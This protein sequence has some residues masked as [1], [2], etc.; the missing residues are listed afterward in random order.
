MP[1]EP[2]SDPATTLQPPS[3]HRK[4]VELAGEGGP[5]I[6]VEDV[7]LSFGDKEVLK[8]VTLHVGH[9]ETVVILGESG[10]GKTVFL[11]V[12]LAL[13]QP[14]QG[15]VKLFGQDLTG[16]NDDELLPVRK[17]CSVVFQDS[18]LYNALTVRENIALELT[19]VLDL[20]DDEV[21]Q[22]VTESLEAVGLSDID[23]DEKPRE[24]SG[25]MRKRLAVAR[26]VAPKP[27]VIVYDEPTSGLDP[28]NSARI[29]ALIQALHDRL[30]V[31]SILVTHDIP[32]A[33]EIASRVVFLADGVVAFDGPPEGF[34]ASDDERIAAFRVSS[35]A[36]LAGPRGERGDAEG[37]PTDRHAP[38]VSARRGVPSRDD[39]RPAAREGGER[40]QRS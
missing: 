6:D 3:L 10:G 36:D 16:L 19:E 20:D 40:A 18:A 12:L 37:R 24:L 33:C 7:R 13:L 29:F 22:R 4:E 1:N 14:T 34:L 8:G 21:E 32:G 15:R 9:G 38:A 39:E 35:P 17:R 2:E 27:E 26:A 23:P 31:T 28:P 11:K 30:G 5:C 25:G